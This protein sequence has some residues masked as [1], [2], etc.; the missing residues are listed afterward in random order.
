MLT[1]QE[2]GIQPTTTNRFKRLQVE[3][4][5][6][7]ATAS[8]DAAPSGDTTESA[9]EAAAPPPK[10]MPRPKIN[11]QASMN[12]DEEEDDDMDFVPEDDEP[13]PAAK[14]RRGRGTFSLE[15]AKVTPGESTVCG[16]CG[17]RFA[18]TRYTYVRRRAAPY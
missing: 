1:G 12:F 8:D 9:E 17:T 2:R 6:D 3:P 7:D 4:E 10:V 18:T 15:P 13:A 16:A 5:S 14:K 11:M